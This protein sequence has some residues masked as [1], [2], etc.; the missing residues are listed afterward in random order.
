MRSDGQAISYGSFLCLELYRDK[1]HFH[2]FTSDIFPCQH[3]SDSF[4]Q[5]R[6][7]N[8]AVTTLLLTI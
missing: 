8:L 5:F 1:D 3:T 4:G 6:S 2:S 7:L